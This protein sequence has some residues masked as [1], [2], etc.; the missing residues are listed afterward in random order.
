MIK[1]SA[2]I[3]LLALRLY[4]QPSAVQQDIPAFSSQ[5]KAIAAAS[6]NPVTL[7]SVSGFTKNNKTVLEWVVGDNQTA[8]LF[9]VE[10]SNDGKEY[11][12]AAIVF[13]SDLPEKASYSFFEKAGSKKQLY[14]VKLVSK[15]KNATYSPVVEITPGV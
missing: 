3:I 8:D 5:Q 13:G 9:E 12:L 1:T 2:L 7:I 15:N 6:N 10:K 4:Y 14:R 11:K